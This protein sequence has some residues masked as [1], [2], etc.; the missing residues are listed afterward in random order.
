MVVKMT[1]ELLSDVESSLMPEEVEVSAPS[2][3]QARYL[4]LKLMTSRRGAKSRLAKKTSLN[5][6]VISHILNH[7]YSMTDEVAFKVESAFALPA[8]FLDQ[9]RSVF[10]FPESMRSLIRQDLSR[11]TDI[12]ALISCQS[13]AVAEDR[14]FPSISEFEKLPS[15]NLNTSLMSTCGAI[16]P[17]ASGPLVQALCLMVSQGIENGSLTEG[18]ALKLIQVLMNDR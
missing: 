16:P 6:S 7:R 15:L 14:T 1:G 5:P 11:V 3:V 10:E 12:L 2:V 4:N 18:M 9:A 17:S 13:T 8:G